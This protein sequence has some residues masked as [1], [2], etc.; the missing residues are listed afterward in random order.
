M[1]I[2]YIAIGSL[3]VIIVA[4]L[5]GVLITAQRKRA[6]GTTWFPENHFFSGS[7]AGTRRRSPDG[8]EDDP[9][10]DCKLDGLSSTKRRKLTGGASTVVDDD[11]QWTDTHYY[12][13]T[14]TRTLTPPQTE[15]DK[16]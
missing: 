9:D 12:G 10:V 5:V 7:A 14:S 11:R 13:N 4:V 6:Y 1:N 2:V 8:G 16:V 3:S 15:G